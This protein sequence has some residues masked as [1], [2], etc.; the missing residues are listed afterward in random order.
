ML[1]NEFNIKNLGNF[2]CSL[3]EA[4]PRL[5]KRAVNTL[6]PFAT[7]YLCESGFSALVSIK[8]KSRNRLDVRDDMRVCLSKTTLQFALLVQNKQEQH[9]HWNISLSWRYDIINKN[10]FLPKLIKVYECTVL[11]AY[12]DF[13]RLFNSVMFFQMVV[14]WKHNCNPLLNFWSTLNKNMCF[15]TIEKY[16][17]RVFI[18][19][20]FSSFFKFLSDNVILR[21]GSVTSI[22]F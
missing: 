20:S 1:R 19:Q 11:H 13:S 9:S 6:I 4:Y 3:S 12:T 22:R 14:S 5:A 10:L 21:K 17:S 7:T 2:W 8:T 16:R 18:K 15:K